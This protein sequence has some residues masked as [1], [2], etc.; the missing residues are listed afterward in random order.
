MKLNLANRLVFGFV[1][2]LLV[3]GANAWVAHNS[4][5]NLIGSASWVSH[6]YEVLREVETDVSLAKDVETGAR[7]YVITA[8]RKFLEPYSKARDKVKNKLEPLYSM[9]SNNPAQQKRVLELSDLV[10]RKLQASQRQIAL[11]DAGRRE[12]AGRLVSS[13]EGKAAM[14]AVRA[15]ANEMRAEEERLLKERMVGLKQAS[16]NANITIWLAMGLSL[17]LLSLVYSGL[18]HAHIQ[19][20]QLAAALRE[21]KRM[22]AMRESL[23][24]MLVHD[25]R[26]PLTTMLGPL[27]LL[28]GEKFGQLEETQREIVNMSL[29]SSRRLLGLVNELLDVAKMEAGE[30]KV[31][32][33]SLRPQ[34]VVDESI[35]HIALAEFDG[36]ARIEREIPEKLPLLQ[37]DQE[38]LTRVL[39]NLLGNAVK[40]TP[41]GGKITLGLRECTP[42]EVLPPRLQPATGQRAA[43]HSQRNGT[44]TPAEEDKLQARSLLFCVRDTGEGVPVEDQDRIFDKFGQVDSRQ[45]GRKMSTG[46][47]L[48]FCKLAVEAHGGFI[49][50]ESEPG[51][52]STFYFT[53]PL[54]SVATDKEEAEKSTAAAA[55]T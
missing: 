39:I 43:T 27:E 1:A 14:D 32:H 38:L 42:L 31:R 48:T 10:D 29:F 55:L 25:L 6:T 18:A 47:G 2:A 15:K 4:V 9:T 54:R 33:D 49:W 51:K 35:K 40:F 37:A 7:G 52:G 50:V 21:V 12:D 46:L 3:L 16:R 28:Q 44:G 13:G 19:G 34:V 45:S 20:E 30:L 53:I 41:S 8:D 17:L 24:A 22:E 11:V 36:A 26:T 5:Q 23:N